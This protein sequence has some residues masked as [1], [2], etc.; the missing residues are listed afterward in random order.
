MKLPIKPVLL[1]KDLYGQS[2]GQV[3]PK[4]LSAI[5]GGKL[6]HL[7]AKAW[8]AMV[9]EAAKAGVVLKPTSPVDTY[10]PL[11]IQEKAFLARYDNTKR[12]TRHEKWKG[13]DWWLKPKMAGVA[14]PG[15]SNH[16]WGLAVDVA[17]MN[18]Q[19]LKWLLANAARFGF[20]WESQSE[21]WHLRY[22]VGDRVPPAVK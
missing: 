20:S 5:T 15:T 12:D 17:G 4:L 13:K 7:A 11:S 14:V 2:N 9:A 1:P 18:D 21:P 8:T 16:G 22:V 3:D 19:R 6:H 10:R